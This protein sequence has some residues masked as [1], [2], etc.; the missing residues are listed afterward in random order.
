MF[1]C[2]Y[3][4]PVMVHLEYPTQNNLKEAIDMKRRIISWLMLATLVACLPSMGLAKMSDADF[5]S[6]CKEGSPSEVQAAIKAGA[7][8][9]ARDEAGWTPLQRA[10]FKNPN[11]KVITILL[12]AG[13][14]VNARDEDGLT[15]LHLAAVANSNTEVIT[16]LLEAGADVNSRAEY[17]STP[18][19]WA[20][21]KN[22]NPEVITTLLKAGADP[23]AKN[24]S[25]KL[26]IELANRNV[27]LQ[28]TDAYKALKRASK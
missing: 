2:G 26:P 3:R 1:S 7:N 11:P 4:L 24:D 21:G 6:L 19:H 20:A 10:A 17:G 22:P 14:D 13:A 27:Y 5:I 9:N 28:G 12:K 16:A 23:K 15:P 18:L 25:G 8:V